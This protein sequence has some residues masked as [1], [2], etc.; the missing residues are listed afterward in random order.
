M[1]RGVSL[2]LIPLPSR[3]R[4]LTKS[5]IVL[6]QEEKKEISAHNAAAEK[7]GKIERGKE[8]SGSGGPLGDELKEAA[9]GSMYRKR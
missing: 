8:K 9:A 3:R 4:G 1:V 6:T 2:L 5:I 7:A